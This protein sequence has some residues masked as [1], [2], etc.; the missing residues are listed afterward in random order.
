MADRPFQRINGAA[1]ILDEAVFAGPICTTAERG[2]LQP[3]EY[4]AIVITGSIHDEARCM[5]S[6]R[7]QPMRPEAELPSTSFP[8]TR[9]R[10]KMREFRVAARG[11][12]QLP[13]N[14]R[15]SSAWR[16]ASS[17]ML[18]PPSLTPW[19]CSGGW[20]ALRF[21]CRSA[22]ISWTRSPKTCC[23]SHHFFDAYLN[24]QLNAEL[25]SEFSLLC[26]ATYYIA[27][28]VGS[29]AV[30]VGK[31]QLQPSTW[32]GASA[33]SSTVFFIRQFRLQSDALTP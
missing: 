4:P 20:C 13:R 32:R 28:H 17:A 24:A 27:G 21:P 18:H 5:P 9:A 25:T 10:A 33:I 26:A 12:Q 3:S 7:G 15:S 19:R 11:L 8:T 2:A 14:P 22:G 29:A 1:A 23:A 31:C 6:T 16:S 30:I